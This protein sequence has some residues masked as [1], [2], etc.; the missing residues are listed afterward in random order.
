[1]KKGVTGKKISRG[2]RAALVLVLALAFLA[3]LTACGGKKSAGEENTT[4]GAY[5][6]SYDIRD[7]LNKELESSGIELQSSAN[8]EFLLNLAEDDSFTLDLDADS[9]VSSLKAAM[10]TDLDSIIGSLM[11]MEVTDDVKGT[12]AAAA[13]YNSYD[14]FKAEMLKVMEEELDEKGLED[15][16]NECHLE[17][18]YE[19]KGTR[20]TF[21]D[22]GESAVVLDAGTI[23]EDGSIKVQSTS[24]GTTVEIV[25]EK[26]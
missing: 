24:S 15:L 16:R 1:M 20:I 6:S 12:I 3:G 13:G 23:Q 18:T 17:G 9:L 22:A 10:E 2:V 26:Q 7:L 14:D 5:Q 4:A 21:K 19:V 8:V 25:F 11:G